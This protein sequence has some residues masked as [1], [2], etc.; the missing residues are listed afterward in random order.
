MSWANGYVGIPYRDLGRDRDGCDCWGLARLIY[1][2]QLGVHLPGYS[3]DYACA[4][5]Q[6]EVGALIDQESGQGPWSRID[7]PEPFDLLLFRRGPHSCHVGIAVSHTRML[8]IVTDDQAKIEA[9]KLSRWGKRYVA[10]FRHVKR[11]LKVPL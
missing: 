10:A 8:H 5:E 3:G 2:E 11:P 1:A 7:A 9:F 4:E 6:A